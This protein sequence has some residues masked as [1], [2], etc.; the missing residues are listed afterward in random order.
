MCLTS[1]KSTLSSCFPE[2]IAKIHIHFLFWVLGVCMATPTRN[3][4]INL[5]KTLMSICMS[6]INFFIHFFFEYYISKNPAVWFA[7]NILTHNSK[8]KFWNI[9]N[10]ILDF[11]GNQKTLSCGHFDPFLFTIGEIKIFLEK[12]TLSAFK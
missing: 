6:K 7:N 11:S 10:K 9:Y 5:L 8:P 4:S 2:D 3:D 1:K 12:R